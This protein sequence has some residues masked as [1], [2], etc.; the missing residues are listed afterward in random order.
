VNTGI[1]DALV[2]VM[3]KNANYAKKCANYRW[4]AVMGS[5]RRVNNATMATR[6]MVMAVPVIAPLNL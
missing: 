3:K 1:A 6:P 5:L 2:G 4:N